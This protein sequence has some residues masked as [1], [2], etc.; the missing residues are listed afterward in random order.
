MTT[1]KLFILLLVIL[2]PLTGCLDIADNAEAEESDDENNPTTT[3]P[4]VH[5]LHIEANSNATIEFDGNHTW[6]VETIYRAGSNSQDL[7]RSQDAAFY[8]DMT[9]DGELMID[10]GVL[11]EDEYI[12]VLGGMPCEVFVYVTQEYFF[13]FSEASLSAL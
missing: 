10:S 7:T 4:M 12:P 1:D 13:V 3:I 2:L 9:C 8:F 11:Y 6:K 5:S